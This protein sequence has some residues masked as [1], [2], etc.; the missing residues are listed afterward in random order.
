MTAPR[1]TVRRDGAVV[2]GENPNVFAIPASEV[3]SSPTEC[4]V[5]TEPMEKP[6]QLP[7]EH[8]FCRDCVAS[9]RNASTYEFC[10]GQR[11]LTRVTCP[12]CRT[13]VN[14]RWLL[15]TLE[16]L[17]RKSR[18]ELGC[19]LPY[20]DVRNSTPPAWPPEL[21]FAP[22]SYR[23]PNSTCFFSS[24]IWRQISLEQIFFS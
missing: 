21:S 15:E 16:S 7:C 17:S 13:P 23:L 12:L 5:C 22:Q 8:V 2:K 19:N 11:C 9:W 10:R 1:S 3:G 20:L 18:N 14:D 24:S 6:I 4:T